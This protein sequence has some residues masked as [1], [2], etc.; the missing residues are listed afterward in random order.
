MFRYRLQSDFVEDLAVPCK[1]L[2]ERLKA[3][4]DSEQDFRI[5]C[6]SALPIQELLITIDK[7]FESKIMMFEQKV[8]L[9]REGSN[10]ISKL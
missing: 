5:I 3:H 9:G 4:F 8:S 7:H 6:T 2:C 10:N 1:V